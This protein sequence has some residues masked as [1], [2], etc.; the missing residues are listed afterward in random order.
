[1]ALKTMLFKNLAMWNEL[2]VERFNIIWTK[3]AGTSMK[4]ALK[5][6]CNDLA[7]SIKLSV[8][9]FIE[10]KPLKTILLMITF[11]DHRVSVTL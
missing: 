10:M 5:I 6:G 8:D 2:S 11:I 4:M 3:V 9:R 1:M 7:I